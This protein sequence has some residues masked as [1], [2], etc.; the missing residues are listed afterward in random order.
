MKS[1][2]SVLVIVMAIFAFVPVLFLASVFTG[3][4][5]FEAKVESEI[6]NGLVTVSGVIFAFQP[7]FF[8]RPKEG[9]LRLAYLA[10]FLVEAVLLGLTGYNYVVSTLDL[11][12]LTISTLLFAA[13]SL[14]LNVSMTAF[15]V[16]ADLAIQSQNRRQTGLDV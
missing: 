16:L 3:K 7:T 15:F 9:I 8:R 1:I 11:G 4:I 2:Y 13:G 12:Y 5:S 10:I 6:V 14:F